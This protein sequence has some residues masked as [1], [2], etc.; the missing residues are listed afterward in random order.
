MY[1]SLT[2]TIVIKTVIFWYEVAAN[3]EIP[4]DIVRINKEY[5]IFLPYLQLSVCYFKLGDVKRS[6]EENNDGPG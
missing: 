3:T 5:Y 4:K 6:E 1:R 2:W